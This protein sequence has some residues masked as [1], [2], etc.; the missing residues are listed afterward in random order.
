M[1][2]E[3]EV[4]PE[5]LLDISDSSKVKPWRSNRNKRKLERPDFVQKQLGRL[6]N[7][8]KT[9]RGPRSARL[10]ALLSARQM[11]HG[12]YPVPTMCPRNLP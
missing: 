10:E 3:Y 5:H 4:I 2:I 9:S 7:S 12:D 8:V 6:I 11:R 1:S